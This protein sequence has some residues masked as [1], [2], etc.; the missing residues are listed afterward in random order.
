MEKI[1][2][3][4]EDKASAIKNLK[5]QFIERGYPQYTLALP[6]PKTAKV[7]DRRVLIFTTKY[8]PNKP[9]YNTI[10]SKFQSIL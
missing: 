8:H 1:N 9:N 7:D 6:A 2:Q 5:E 4:P 3:T 10:W